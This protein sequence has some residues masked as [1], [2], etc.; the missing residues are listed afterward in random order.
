MSIRSNR[1][2]CR[3]KGRRGLYLINH[4]KQI[5]VCDYIRVSALARD[6]YGWHCVIRFRDHDNRRRCLVLREDE[7]QN[8]KL[9][10]TLA[11]EGFNIPT[12]PA[13]RARLREYLSSVRPRCRMTIAR[14]P[15]W[16]GD[17]YVLPDAIVGPDRAKLIYWPRGTEPGASEFSA[18]PQAKGTL[19]SWQQ[20]VAKP[21]RASSR[22]VFLISAAFAPPLLH[23]QKR[24]SYLI[25]LHGKTTGGK[26]TAEIVARSVFGLLTRKGLQHWDITPA[27]LEE[28]AQLHCDQILIIDDMARLEDAKGGASKTISAFIYQIAGQSAKERSKRYYDSSPTLEWRIIVLTSSEDSLDELA[29]R[30]KRTRKPGE[31]MRVIDLPADSGKGLGIFDRLPEDVPTADHFSKQLEQACLKSYGTPIRAFVPYIVDKDRCDL[32]KTIDEYEAEFLEAIRFDTQNSSATRRH[33]E[34]FSLIYGAGCLAIDAAILPWKKK[35]VLRAC[36]RCY[37]AA[38]K[39]RRHGDVAKTALDESVTKLKA[40]LADAKAS[41][42]G[43]EVQFQS[44]PKHGAFAALLPSKLETV[45]VSPTTQTQFFGHLKTRGVLISGSGGKT[46]R[47]ISINGQRRRFLCIRSEFWK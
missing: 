24:E 42:A 22:L 5:R 36:V 7:R 12:S 29:R 14:F 47:Q 35:T 23:L 10:D 18:A 6:T 34:K 20:N 2:V 46:T 41:N 30:D 19:G 37:R 13:D 26:T 1:Y 4:R 31:K 8:P 43:G 15:G 33:V 38:R 32:T 40:M 39:A 21:A 17:T 27:R 44:D 3:A 28:L 25:V 16:Y 11:V 45:L 9:L